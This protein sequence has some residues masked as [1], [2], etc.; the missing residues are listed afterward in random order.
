MQTIDNLVKRPA[1]FG[2]RQFDQL[3]KHRDVAA[4]AEMRSR[5]PQQDDASA[6]VFGGFGGGVGEFGDQLAICRIQHFGA[7][8]DDFENSLI[9]SQNNT[10]HRSAPRALR[11]MIG[12]L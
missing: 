5:A 10:G 9:S 1:P 12:R 6:A 8:Q 7:V 11:S 4:S 2:G 3:T